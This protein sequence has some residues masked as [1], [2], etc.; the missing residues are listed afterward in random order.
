MKSTTVRQLCAELARPDLG[1]GDGHPDLGVRL[2]VLKWSSDG[3]PEHPN[4]CH[5][6]IEPRMP[7]LAAEDLWVESFEAREKSFVCITRPLPCVAI[8]VYAN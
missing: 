4:R 1:D 5:L 2:V 7:L 8:A 3:D 6:A